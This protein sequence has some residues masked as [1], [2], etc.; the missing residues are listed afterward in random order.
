MCDFSEKLITW[1]DQELGEDEAAKVEQHLRSCV[2]CQREVASYKQV[3]SAFSAYCDAVM[4]SQR[5]GRLPRWVPV[6][7]GVAA[8]AA[9]VLLAF[10]HAP[11]EQPAVHPPTA[12]VARAVARD[13][14]PAPMS[15]REPALRRRHAAVPTKRE[16]ANWAPAEPAIRI[17]IPAEAMFAPGAVPEGVNFVADL[18]IAADGSAQRLQLQPQLIGLERRTTQP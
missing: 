18:S 17:V 7:A 1:L 5:P 13:V 4:A 3:S 8:A 15:S 14:A 11:V 10:R 2:E 9:L 6:L 16:N 12:A